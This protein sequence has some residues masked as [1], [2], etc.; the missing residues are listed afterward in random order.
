MSFSE[1]SII[2]LKSGLVSEPSTWKTGLPRRPIMSKFTIVKIWPR[3]MPSSFRFL[4]MYFE[5]RS[6]RSS[7]EKA[8]KI[9]ERLE[10]G[11][12]FEFAR[13]AKCFAAMM[14]PAVPEALSSAPLWILSS[15]GLIVPRVREP[16][17]RWPSCD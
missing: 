10:A 3:L 15:F 6:P 14:T 5:P 16:W 9:I 4:V 8:V 7:P 1:A 2:A 11:A 17:T 13:R 12:F